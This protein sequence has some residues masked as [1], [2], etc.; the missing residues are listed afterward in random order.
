[1]RA[2]RPPIINVMFSVTRKVHGYPRP[3][4]LKCYYILTETPSM[5][6]VY[7]GTDG[8]YVI[9]YKIFIVPACSVSKKK[10]TV[11]HDSSP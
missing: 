4:F 5:A 10:R 11:R 3:M 6:Y 7:M 8:K 1:M 2:I 9:T